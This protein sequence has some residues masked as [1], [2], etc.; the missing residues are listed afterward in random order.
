MPRLSLCFSIAVAALVTAPAALAD[1]GPVFASQGG[2]GVASPTHPGIHYVVLPNGRGGTLLETI[3][4]ANDDVEAGP[5]IHG[6][7]GIPTI[8]YGSAAG[9]GL[10][11][12]GR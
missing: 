7:W 10:S 5:V 6:S 1:G 4:T 9:Q 3:Y 12:D 8:G 2:T 11:H